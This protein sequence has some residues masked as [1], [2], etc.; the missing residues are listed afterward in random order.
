MCAG[1]GLHARGTVSIEC[2]FRFPRV[3][4]ILCKAVEVQGGG[5]LAGECVCAGHGSGLVRIPVSSYC[6]LLLS[7]LELNEAKV[8]EP[9]I[10]SLL[11]SSA[12]FCNVVVLKLRTVSFPVSQGRIHSMQ[13]S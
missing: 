11:G 4:F 1:H 2:R 7:S 12:H 3:G 9:E 8:Y 10:R 6:S 13:G 5:D